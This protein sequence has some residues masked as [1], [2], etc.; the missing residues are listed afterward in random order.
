MSIGE[1]T[2]PAKTHIDHESSRIDGLLQQPLTLSQVPHGLYGQ[3]D[4]EVLHGRLIN[5]R[6]DQVEHFLGWLGDDLK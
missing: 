4:T 6:E 2:F 3:L 1:T 5:Y